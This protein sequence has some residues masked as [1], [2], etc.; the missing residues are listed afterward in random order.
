MGAPHHLTSI[1]A[2]TGLSTLEGRSRRLQPP[3]KNTKEETNS[4][5]SR[6]LGSEEVSEEPK[7]QDEGK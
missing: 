1:H 2:F 3:P 4:R 5:A 6:E 7:E